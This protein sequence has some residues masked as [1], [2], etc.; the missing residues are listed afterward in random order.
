MS[1]TTD[2]LHLPATAIREIQD[3]RLRVML[4]LCAE[5]H[6]FYREAWAGIDLGTI[7]GV[8][9]L[10]RLPLTTKRALMDQ[11]ER[12]RLHC[13]AL[14]LAQRALWE[15]VH[16]TGSSGDPTPIYNTTH[17]YHAYLLLNRR[18]AEIAGI[19][20]RDMI[21]NLFPL[22]AASMGA[23]MRSST[24]AYG[25]GA[26]VAASL[27]GA[28]VGP[29]GVQN[30]MVEALGI[31]ER[32]RATVLWGVTSFIRK[33]LLRAIEVG[34]DFRSVRM[35]AMTGE[36]SS[37]ELREEL[38]RLLRQLGAADTIIFDRYGSTESGGLS[39]CV[40]D[41]PWHNPAPE[42][43]HMEVVDPATGQTLPDGERGQLAITHL[44]RRGTVLIRYL[45][46]DVVSLDQ[47]PCPHCGRTSERVCG[48]V[49]RTK[50]LIKVKGMLI[51]PDLLLAAMQ[52]LD[53]LDEFQVVVAKQDAAD[54]FSMD[55]LVV[56]V[57]TRAEKAVMAEAVSAATQAAI[58][59]RPRVVFEPPRAIYDPSAH[60]KATRFVDQR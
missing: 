19:T 47:S 16:T 5:G 26:A 21:A 38:R 15:V 28:P 1:N 24:L 10:H 32:H 48:P 56:R 55:E 9:D 6:D 36:A 42:L 39:Q 7:R 20:N 4:A 8:A 17:D 50:D 59:V 49:V 33:L 12:F 3:D 45:V 22:T 44:D 58:G 23:F 35:I 41:G 27:G 14:P 37:P 2:I 53:G 34:A 13:P 18:V 52:G 54:P 46:G 29:F 60:T 40:Q 57:E 30:S 43:L 25:A 51:N 31:V 11:P